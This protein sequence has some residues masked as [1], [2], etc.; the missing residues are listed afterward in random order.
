M[1][2]E[3]RD[4][5]HCYAKIKQWPNWSG[6]IPQKGDTVLIHFGDDNG[7][8]KMYDVKYRLISETEPDKVIIMVSL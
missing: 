2:L 7:K 1:T 8:E 5:R 3:F 4:I 6:E